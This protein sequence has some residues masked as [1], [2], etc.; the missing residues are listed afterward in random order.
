M[1]SVGSL[2][3]K[4][5][6]HPIKAL[7]AL[8]Q[9]GIKV[10]KKGGYGFWFGKNIILFESHYEFDGN[11]GALYKYL[12]AR[13]KY[14]KYTFVW[15]VK[16]FQDGSYKNTRH[17][18]VFS[19]MNR[20][21]K[22]KYLM[23]KAKFAFFD[24]V[25]IRAGGENAKTI[26]LTHGQLGLKNV[27]GI[28]NMPNYVDNAL[29]I[30]EY[31]KPFFCNNI[32]CPSEKI[33]ICG[34]P[35]ND[36]IFEKHCEIKEYFD[37]YKYNKVVLWLPTFRKVDWCERNDTKK[38]LP[39]GIPLF[40]SQEQFQIVDNFLKRKNMLLVLKL[41]PRQDLTIIRDVN[42]NNIIFITHKSLVKNGIGTNYL[43]PHAD[44]M[45]SDYSSAATDF[46]LL[47]KPLAYI[48]EDQED[49]KLNLPKEVYDTRT[50]GN[51]IKTI[52]EL[53]CFLEMVYMG[54]DEFK[55]Q[56]RALVNLVHTYK[57]GNNCKRIAD[58]FNI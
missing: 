24:D 39:F 36:V 2:I 23:Q 21:S 33:F 40:Y 22:K 48:V 12:R 37:E 50:P 8:L 9:A 44:A 17:D 29:C 32:G 20:S 34:L 28:I 15:I 35:R 47:D 31:Y 54:E 4:C 41:H 53:L 38:E 46:M 45:I 16:G 18:L 25:P 19:M 42:M 14:D 11:S 26:Y 55:E 52:N 43:Y 56:R 5:F 1:N 30:S 3:K 51:K 27:K 58:K 13:K 7:K 6:R 49:Y 57:D 10:A